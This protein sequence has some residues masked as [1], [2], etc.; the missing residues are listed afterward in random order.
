M[1]RKWITI[2][3]QEVF[4]RYIKNEENSTYNFTN[5]MMWS[6]EGAI[7]YAEVEGCLAL[8]FQFAKS[9]VTVSYPM[10][11]GNKKAAILALSAYI[12]SLGLRPVFRNLSEHMVM[13][14]EELFPGE[15]EFIEDRDTADYIYETEKMITLSGKKLHAKRNHLNYFKNNVNYTYRSLK[16]ED[17]PACLALFDRWIGE[18]EEMHLLDSSREATKRLLDN[19][20]KLP[21][22]GGGIFIDGELSAFSIGEPVTE[23]TALI[24]VEYALSHRGIFNAISSEFCADAWREFAFVNREEDMG[25]SGLRHAKMAYRPVR[26][27]TKWNAVPKHIS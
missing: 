4:S 8:F 27:L 14:M 5:M 15:Y 3:D 10:G 7:T 11:E 12:K 17:M 9:P 16:G 19:F 24:H 26:L 21:V 13:E 1:E 20:D 18:K 23:E 6:G 22:R 2:E 25:L